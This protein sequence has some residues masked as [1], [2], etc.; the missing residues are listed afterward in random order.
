MSSFS[1]RSSTPSQDLP[2]ECYFNVTHPQDVVQSGR[3]V[4]QSTHDATY[5]TC[6]AARP[7]SDINPSTRN[8]SVSSA[9]SSSTTDS[10]PLPNQSHTVRNGVQV[11]IKVLSS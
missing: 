6:D 2:Q 1:T 4:T 10:V 11:S 8:V 7:T 3:E 9:E 5:P